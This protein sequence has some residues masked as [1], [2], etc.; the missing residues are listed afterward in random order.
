M[1]QIKL[2]NI[3]V[4]LDFRMFSYRQSLL[5]LLSVLVYLAFCYSKQTGIDLRKFKKMWQY[6]KS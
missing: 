2:N 1:M 4:F 6:M 5:L 3:E